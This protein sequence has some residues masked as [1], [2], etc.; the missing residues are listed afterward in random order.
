MTPPGAASARSLLVVL[1]CTATA[2]TQAQ[3]YGRYVNRTAEWTPVG[4]NLLH[5]FH[6]MYNLHVLETPED[7]AYPFKGWF[8][9]W[10]VEDCNPGYPG[11]DAICAARAPA[12]TG[13]WEVYAGEQDGKAAW[14]ATMTPARWVPVIAG[15]DRY[16]NNW[17]IGDPSVVRVGDTF[18]MAYSA[19]GFNL[20]G[21]PYGRPGDTD[22]DIS[23]IMGATSDDGLR[24]RISDAPILVD[25]AN[26]GQ[27][28]V[29]PGGYQHPTGIYHRPSILHEDGRFKIWFDSCV[30]GKPCMMLYAENVGDFMNPADWKILRGMDNPCIYEFP[31]PDVVRVGDVYYAYADPGGHPGDGW[32]RRKTTEAASINGRDWILL[33]YID[34]DDDVQAN[35]VP[36][37][38]V[39]KDAGKTW[40]YLAY[41]GQRRGDFRYGCI[42]M[43]RR[44]ITPDELERITALCADLAPGP[45][46]FLPP[47][48]KE[49]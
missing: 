21:I 18:H 41:A 49:P 27:A 29:E 43:R 5:R 23:C 28:P 1:L 11:C 33:G 38:T 37:A 46:P 26:I 47:P 14:D 42:R 19:T 12:I 6:N 4:G 2:A 7:P 32:T 22:S 45:L 39:I 9:G 15:G 17:H 24:W 25:A 10:M 31:N 35:H 34:A 40:I 30:Y 48:T 20:D 13:P 8:F 44:E 16:Y 3:D 36:E